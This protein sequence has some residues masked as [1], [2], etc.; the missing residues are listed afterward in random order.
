MCGIACLFS[1]QPLDDKLI[2][3]MTTVISHRGP[4]DEGH[5][6][7]IENRVILGHRRLSIVDLSVAGH[8]PM[9]YGDSK[10]WITYNGEIY[11]YVELRKELESL[12]CHFSS[13]T[14]TEVILAAYATWGKGC[15]S[16]FNGMWAFVIVHIKSNKIFASRDRFG[17]KPFYYWRSPKGFWAFSSEIKQFT[18]LPG[19]EARMNRARVYDFLGWG[20]T[21][22]TSE[23]LFSEVF[24]LRGGEAFEISINTLPKVLPIYQWYELRSTVYE[25]TFQDAVENFRVLFF[26]AVK[27]RLRADVSIGS[28]LSG[29]L[30]SSSIV[31]V[32]N[33]LLKRNGSDEK[34]RTVS[35]CSEEKEYDER[36][37]IDE[38]VN[39]RNLKALYTYPRGDSLLDTLRELIWYQDEPFASTSIF[40]QWCVYKTTAENGLK[41]ML[42][43]QGAD[44]QLAGYNEFVVA[45]FAHLFKRMQWVK[46]AE[47]IQSCRRLRGDNYSFVIKGIANVLLPERI[48]QKART[49][50]NYSRVAPDWLDLQRLGVYP[51]DPVVAA[52]AV[53]DDMY[54]LSFS[55]LTM[56]TLPRLLRFEDR[57]SMAH[58]VEARLPF[59]DY[60]LVEF[61]LSLPD[62]MKFFRGVTKRVLRESMKG[63]LPNKIYSRFDKMGFVTPEEVW[64]RSG[65]L[66]EF[67]RMME[68]AIERSQGILLPKALDHLNAVIEGRERFSQ[69]IWRIIIF[70]EWLDRFNVS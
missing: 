17:I 63:I 8:Q 36:H 28:C 67:K 50:Q 47:E 3:Q 52:G 27:L 49:W 66:D 21:D 53:T 37:F 12:G 19:W 48:R 2:K 5:I 46:L 31:C 29:G 64:V 38:V 40:S 30:D 69:W 58:S 65:Y 51:R 56:I 24:Q 6:G 62:D 68:L 55:Q 59:L 32:M 54:K 57:N 18:V 13:R 35:A 4:D 25:G 11:N 60:R 44:E 14:D 70:G 20:L 7:L 26:D 43:G 16:R 41:V 1:E 61:V 9:T 15:I 34:Q 33:D 22:H 23:T 45:R 42:D 10:Y 39:S